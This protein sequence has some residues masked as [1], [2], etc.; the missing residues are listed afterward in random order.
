MWLSIQRVLLKEP[1]GSPVKALN[2]QRYVSKIKMQDLGIKPRSFDLV[3]VWSIQ[4]KS[5]AS[6]RSKAKCRPG[7][8]TQILNLEY[9]LNAL[10]ML[11]YHANVKYDL[12]PI[13]TNS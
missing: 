6:V 11:I 7:C 4:A 1:D 3:C 9:K 2:L 8:Q 5:A 12:L 10:Q 13:L